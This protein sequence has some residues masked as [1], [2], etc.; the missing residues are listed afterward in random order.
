[1]IA[2]YLLVLTAAGMQIVL[3]WCIYRTPFPAHPAQFLVA[4]TFV[5][6]AFLG[7]GLLI[8]MLADSVP[9]VQALGQ[10]IFLPMILI[11]GVGVPLRALPPGP[12]VSRLFCPGVTR[13]R[14]C[15]LASRKRAAASPGRASRS[16]RCLLSAPRA[17]SP[18][19]RFSGGTRARNRGRVPEFWALCALAAWASVGLAAAHTGRWTLPVDAATGAATAP[20]EKWRAITDSDL[21]AIRYDNLPPDDGIVAPL[22]ANLDSLDGAGSERLSTF[23]LKLANW[24]PLDAPDLVQRV[25]N[26]LSVCAIP[27]SLE[28][29]LEADIP[30]VVF[31]K[32]E[33]EVPRDDLEKALGWIVL[34]PMEGTIL[35]EISPLGIE[36]APSTERIRE[37]SGLYARK[38]L[39]RLLGAG[40]TPSSVRKE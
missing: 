26:A 25:R 30:F 4:F 19:R 2:R 15:R 22:A 33:A 24:P 11:G 1:M 21:R 29:P 10:A 8:A 13:S 34:H 14:R 6:F 3:A 23:E 28:D 9:A 35:H 17:A 5:C 39:R 38:L 27:D 18:G 12:C 37:R 7:M 40:L 20:G 36:G 16:A 31:A 32:L